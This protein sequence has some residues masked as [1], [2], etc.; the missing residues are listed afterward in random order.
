MLQFTIWQKSYE[1]CGFSDLLEG[2]RKIAKSPVMLSEIL[3]LLYYE[4]SFY[5]ES[6]EALFVLHTDKRSG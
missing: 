2:F 4:E 5:H 3:E 1:D 6:E